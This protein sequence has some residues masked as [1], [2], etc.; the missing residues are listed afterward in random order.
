[1]ADRILRTFVQRHQNVA[2]V[3]QLRIHRGPR[4]ESVRIAVQ[5]TLKCDAFFADFSEAAQTEYLVPSRIRQNRVG[6]RHEPMQP[7][8]IS[9]RLETGPQ[10]Q[11]IG[12]GQQNLYAQILR[13]VAGRE[14]L[15]R[16]LRAHRHKDRRLNGSV[17]GVENTSPGAGVRTFGHHFEAKIHRILHWNMRREECEFLHGF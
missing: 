10:I 11:V 17:R 3:R 7:A 16:R 1:M 5:M 4:R 12:V 13:Q 9:D 8:Q 15:H 14:S 2:S 6:P